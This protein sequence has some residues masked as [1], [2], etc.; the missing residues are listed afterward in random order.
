MTTSPRRIGLGYLCAALLIVAGFA[1]PAQPQQEIVGSITGKVFDGDSRTPLP[2]VIVK[3][4]AITSNRNLNSAATDERGA[5]FI[6]RAPASLYAFTLVHDGIDYAVSQR[7]DARTGMTFL[8]D[9]CIRLDRKSRSASVIPG[10]CAAELIAQA[11]VVT[12]GPHRFLASQQSTGE[13]LS[14]FPPEE[15]PGEGNAAAEPGAEAQDTQKP[16][17]QE[18]MDSQS[19]EPDA[20]GPDLAGTPPADATAPDELATNPTGADGAQ[21]DSHALQIEHDQIE[22]LQHNQFPLV[23]SAVRPGPEVA[24]C[25]VYFR[26]DK[27]PDFYYVEATEIPETPEDFRAILPKP[28]P[29]TERVIYYVEAVSDEY[30]IF[31]TEEADPPVVDDACERDPAGYYVGDNPNIVVGATSAGAAAVPP[32]FQALGI[33]GFISAAG[34]TTAVTAVAAAGGAAA[35]AGGIS[36]ALIVVVSGAAVA[37][38]GTIVNTVINNGSEAEASNP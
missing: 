20:T 18:E 34:V 38:G 21:P 7:V 19:P 31:Q 22:C 10:D 24:V 29:E 16:D 11:Q 35:A 14:L 13:P 25:R 17:V 9:N 4:H 15:T 27:Y 8:L 23:D 5:F 2:N 36:T 30:E 32:G 12:I 28:S 1:R 33:T 26:S 6:S 3:A 37:T